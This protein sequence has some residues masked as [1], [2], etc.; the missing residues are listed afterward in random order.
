MPIR[1]MAATLY[2]IREADA[3]RDG[4]RQARELAEAMDGWPISRIAVA[5]PCLRCCQTVIP[6][7][8]SRRLQIESLEIDNAAAAAKALNGCRGS[9]ALCV[10]DELAV[11][12][13]ARLLGDAYGVRGILG[14]SDLWAWIIKRDV[15]K[16]VA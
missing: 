6:L 11:E 2:L 3:G 5:G 1:D 10:H 9:L 7:A 15:M 16:V 13:V 12:I 14:G 8:E 4:L